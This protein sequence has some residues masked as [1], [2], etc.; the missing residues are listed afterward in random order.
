M[1]TI[2]NRK[3]LC[4][5]YDMAEQARVREIL[6]QNDIAYDM[7][8][9]N[10]LSPSSMAAGVRARTGSLGTDLE[11]NYEYKIYVHKDDYEQAEFLL[12]K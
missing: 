5:T 11:K 2:F 4:I 1:L 7:K 6:S 9:K 8:V 3:E 10:R 12:R